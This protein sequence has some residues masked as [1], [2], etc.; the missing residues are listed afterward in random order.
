MISQ[1]ELAEQFDRSRSHLRAVAFRML[2]SADE[3]DDAVQ[4]VWLGGPLDR[5]A[6]QSKGHLD[7][8]SGPRD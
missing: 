4:E 1:A 8:R 5:G 2:G 7:D 3:A 6:L